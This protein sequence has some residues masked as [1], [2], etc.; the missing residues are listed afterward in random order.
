[1]EDKIRENYA[2]LFKYVK[3]LILEWN[4][5][6]MHVPGDEYD[7][8]VSKACWNY[9][10][11]NDIEKFYQNIHHYLHSSLGL[12]EIYLDDVMVNLPVPFIR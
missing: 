4:P 3:Q 1:M 10:R 7:E 2:I 12:R 11:D 6:G 5:I 8:M 9:I